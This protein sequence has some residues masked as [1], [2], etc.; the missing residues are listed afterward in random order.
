MDIPPSQNGVKIYSEPDKNFTTLSVL[1]S[2]PA[3]PQPKTFNLC[4]LYPDT[5]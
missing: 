5:P 3:P 2:I 4:V 1:P